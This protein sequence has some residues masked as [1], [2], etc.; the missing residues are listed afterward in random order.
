MRNANST[1]AAHRRAL[2]VRMAFTSTGHRG[3]TSARLAGAPSGS[4]L[5]APPPFVVRSRQTADGRRQRADFCRWPYIRSVRCVPTPAPHVCAHWM[6][7]S[8]RLLALPS[9]ATCRPASRDFRRSASSRIGAVHDIL[10]PRPPAGGHT[11]T[12]PGDIHTRVAA[13]LRR[14]SWSAHSFQSPSGVRHCDGPSGSSGS[15]PSID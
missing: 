14:A 8:R 3:R 1:H 4:A 10:S 2:S 11:H 9:V 6:H 7:L 12:A 15:C 5:A 13:C